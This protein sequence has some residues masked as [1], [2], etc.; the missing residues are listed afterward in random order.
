[1]LDQGNEGMKETESSA[2]KLIDAVLAQWEHRGSSAIS[3]RSLTTQA[4]VPV[5]SLYHHFG[6]LEH[7][8]LSSQAHARSEAE[9]WCA[10]H[11]DTLAIAGWLP[12]SAFP[13]LLAVLID[14]WTEQQR[15]IAFAWRE[16]VLASAREASFAV[17]VEA[18]RALWSRFWQA[19][20]DRCGQSRFG[21]LTTLFFY[22]E[23]LFHLIRWHRA[24]DCAALHDLC[25]GWARWLEG[26]LA[27]EGPWRRAAREE[28]ARTMPSLPVQGELS[29]RIAEAAATILQR[30][31]LSALTHRAVAAEAGLTL[32]V[33]S[34]NVRTSADLVRAAFEMVYRQVAGNDALTPE[35]LE[36]SDAELI[37]RLLGFQRDERPL[38]S[39]DEL[40]LAVARDPSLGSFIPQ[41]RYM[42]GRTSG[43]LL[44]TIA[45]GGRT[46]SPLDHALLSAVVSGMRQ[47][48]LG[49]SAEE[50][51]RRVEQTVETLTGMLRQT[52]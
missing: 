47:S 31:G 26:E 5:S 17:E 2:Q 50:A 7:L 42:R 23:S 12:P 14:D 9:R 39:L 16:C 13:A 46:G 37:E 44:P 8:Y 18:W 10:G 20:C 49:T 43:T 52:T 25:A 48:C 35:P 41:L 22:N 30:D 24:I 1:M 45:G 51:R 29:G 21:G 11:L 19:V 34:H 38:P 15:R 28:A 32:G 3:A 40:L 27:E 6:N 33:V 4:G 36:V